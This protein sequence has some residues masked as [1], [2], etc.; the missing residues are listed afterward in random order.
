MEEDWFDFQIAN[1]MEH[2]WTKFLKIHYER[3]EEYV[4][5]ISGK[6][7]K[8]KNWLVVIVRSLPP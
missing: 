6:Q 2:K 4:A 3:T 1:S 5:Q 7:K 8:K